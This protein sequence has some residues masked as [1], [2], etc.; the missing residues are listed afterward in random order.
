MPFTSSELMQAVGQGPAADNRR[1]SRSKGGAAGVFPLR[2]EAPK[3]SHPPSGPGHAGHRASFGDRQNLIYRH[4]SKLRLVPDW[5]PL[6]RRVEIRRQ[7]VGRRERSNV[8]VVE[9]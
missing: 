6:R 7:G 2:G 8:V 1:T 5:L 4:A 3:P 9:V